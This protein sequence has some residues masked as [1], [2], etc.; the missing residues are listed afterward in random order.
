MTLLFLKDRVE[1]TYKNWGLFPTKI[2]LYSADILELEF[3]VQNADTTTNTMKGA[4]AG[5][6]IAGGL[7]ALA[8][9]GAASKRRKEDHLHLV[10]N[11]KGQPRT[12]YF[13]RTKNTQRM[14]QAFDKIFS[15]KPTVNKTVTK[16]VNN[17][18]I[19]K[20]LTDLNILLQQGILTQLEFDIQ[21][22]K[23]LSS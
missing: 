14:F 20:Q 7:G 16:T 2:V 17:G 4:I 1:I 23:I 15:S 21:K 3:G 11:Y 13:Q 19:A 5:S 6:L 8:L 18:D 10:I 12:L 22:Q 9:A